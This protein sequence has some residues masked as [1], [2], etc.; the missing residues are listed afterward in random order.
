M[1]KQIYRSRKHRMIAGVMGGIAEH[2]GWSPTL[3]RLIFFIAFISR[4]KVPGVLIYI[5]LWIAMP[6]P[7]N[8]VAQKQ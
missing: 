7:K 8:A 6:D 4:A 1:I 2:M 3:L 5:L